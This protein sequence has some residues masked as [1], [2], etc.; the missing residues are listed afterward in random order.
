LKITLNYDKGTNI[1]IQISKR[2][3]QQSAALR[4]F[5]HERM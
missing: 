4:F 2:S 5:A 1:E 3:L